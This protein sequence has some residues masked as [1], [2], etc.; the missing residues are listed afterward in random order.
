MAV[1]APVWE[2]FLPLAL[3]QAGLCLFVAESE[4][5]LL[6]LMDCPQGRSLLFPL[7]MYTHLHIRAAS[8]V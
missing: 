5:I 8:P 3:Y 2:D 4:H 1:R 6:S 7:R